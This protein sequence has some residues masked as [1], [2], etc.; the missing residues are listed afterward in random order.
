[1]D[2]PYGLTVHNSMVALT[3]QSSR[4]NLYKSTKLLNVESP[5]QSMDQFAHT[6]HGMRIHTSQP[7]AS[8][9]ETNQSQAATEIKAVEFCVQEKSSGEVNQDYAEY[10]LPLQ[11]TMKT[12][13]VDRSANVTPVIEEDENQVAA[14]K[15]VLRKSGES[16]SVRN[17]T[18]HV[19]TVQEVEEP[20]SRRESQGHGESDK[21]PIDEVKD[22][23]EV[24]K[25]YTDEESREM[26]AAWERHAINKIELQ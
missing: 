5:K 14:L 26:I 25:T 7:A 8:Q 18:Q 10:D 13:K 20:D 1:M 2:H 6:E 12:E 22:E 11:M 16:P 9:N 24:Q 19:S 4:E 17:F 21:H 23:E 15:D 3:S